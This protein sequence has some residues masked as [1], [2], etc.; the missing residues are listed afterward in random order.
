VTRK[1]AK[2]VSLV[3]H[4]ILIPIYG[5]LAISTF[6][7]VVASKL[8]VQPKVLMLSMYC[9]L[10]SILPLLGV[11]F[12]LNK[13]KIEELSSIT[14]PER[15][16]AAW[17]LCLVYGLEC[18]FMDNYF[19]HPFLRL[20]VLALCLSAG[21]LAMISAFKKVS[22]HVFGWAGFL[23][24][25]AVLGT[26]NNGMFIFMVLGAL[27][28]TGLVASARLSLKAHTKQEVYLGFITGLISN[29]AVYLFFDGRL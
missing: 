28:I 18:W 23:V 20:F 4:P 8:N 10:L 7:L 25:I 5:V 15:R 21:V 13:Y 2:V 1:F 22:F 14:L 17:A 27:V 6:H 19:F 3:F 12:L 26:K 16:L 9:I 11:M 24:L 29:I